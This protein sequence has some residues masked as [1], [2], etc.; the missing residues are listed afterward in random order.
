MTRKVISVRDIQ[1]TDKYE[2]EKLRRLVEALSYLTSE[3][4]KIQ[5]LLDG[6]EDGQTLIKNSERDYD[7]DWT[8][9]GGGGS[10][11]ETN[12]AANV[13][14]GVGLYRDKTGVIL[15]FRSLLAG[16]G[17]SIAING[18]DVEI[19]TS[20]GGDGYPTVLGHAGI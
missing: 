2:G 19:S 8:D 9:A 15:N 11:G 16:T 12:D 20:G 17:V 3:V 6:G 18:D 13:G 5:Q 14:T 10:A 1:F 4:R 7:A